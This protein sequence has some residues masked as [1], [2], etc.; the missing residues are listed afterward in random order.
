MPSNDLLNGYWIVQTRMVSTFLV[1]L[2]QTSEFFSIEMD[3]VTEFL[4]VRR[5]LDSSRRQADRLA[6]ELLWQQCQLVFVDMVITYVDN[7]LSCPVVG[8]VRH[9]VSEGCI[10]RDI[11][12]LACRAITRLS[13]R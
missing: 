13:I 1:S 7:Q 6:H 5:I 11:E 3:E 8:D 12:G 4:N 9:Q 2:D 10:L